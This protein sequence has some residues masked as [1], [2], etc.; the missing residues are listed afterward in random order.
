MKVTLIQSN[1]RIL[2]KYLDENAAIEVE[3]QLEEEGIQLL[4]GT[5][6]TSYHTIDKKSGVDLKSKLK[7][8]LI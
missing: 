7:L 3:K 5:R 1:A 6:V 8:L 2:D 4:L